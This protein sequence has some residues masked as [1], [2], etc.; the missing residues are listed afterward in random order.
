MPLIIPKETWKETWNIPSKRRRFIIGTTSMMS[1]VFSMPLFFKHIEKRKGVLLN[2]FVLAAITPH[3][4]SV[5]I[6]AVIWGMVT[7]TIVRAVK[8][9]SIYILYCWTLIS[10]TILRFLA[11]TFVALD[12]PVGLIPLTDPLTGV[13][14]GQ[15]LI[16]KDLFFSGHTATLTLMFLCLERRNDKIAGFLAI[17]AVAYLLLVQHIHYTIDIIASPI[18][19]YTCYRFT[20]YFLYRNEQPV[21][22]SGA[23]KISV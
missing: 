6:F 14:Y 19:T 18:I 10:V 21:V 3:N 12:P 23:D 20:K 13:F 9:S 15:A 5:L 17:V 2:D 4:V 16:V 8:N 11:I 1:L 22:K 7:L